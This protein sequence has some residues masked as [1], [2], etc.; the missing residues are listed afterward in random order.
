MKG[1][2]LE[3]GLC[4][5]ESTKTVNMTQVHNITQPTLADALLN[6]YATKSRALLID[7]ALI[8]IFAGF[9]SLSAQ[10]TIPLPFTPVPITGQTLAVL[11]TGTVI[12][13]RRGCASLV[14][15]LLLGACGA[16]VFAGGATGAMKFFGATGG[17][18][19]SYPIASA[20][21]GALAQRGWDRKPA[22][23]FGLMALG[24]LAIYVPGVLWLSVFTGSLGSALMKGAVP[25]V[26]GDV[27]KIGIAMLMMPGAWRLVKRIER[28]G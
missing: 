18:L 6:T 5:L 28:E 14:L 7:A 2:V 23:L 13:A 24:N 12:G 3:A 26:L 22:K 16:H 27:V 9:V 4:P 11:L 17:Y 20:I 19:L 10:I 15:Y 21:T 1:Q 8:G 25:F